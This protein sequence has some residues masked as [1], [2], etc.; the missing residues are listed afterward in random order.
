[1]NRVKNIKSII[2]TPNTPKQTPI[3][4]RISFVIDSPHPMKNHLHKENTEL[5]VVRE[6]LHVSKVPDSLPCRESEYSDIF[7]FVYS[8]LSTDSSG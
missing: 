4:R 6:K 7:N 1:M 2:K 5:D 3:R 8:K